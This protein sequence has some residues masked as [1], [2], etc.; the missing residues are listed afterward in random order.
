M[1]V[2]TQAP[3]AS[4]NGQD[5]LPANWCRAPEIPQW[6]DITK[7]DSNEAHEA[8][9]LANPHAGTNGDGEQTVSLVWRD[10]GAHGHKPDSNSIALA[11]EDDDSATGTRTV[12]NADAACDTATTI[13]GIDKLQVDTFSKCDDKS[14]D[15]NTRIGVPISTRRGGNVKTDGATSLFSQL[16]LGNSLTHRKDHQ[17]VRA[18][19]LL[20]AGKDGLMTSKDSKEYEHGD[21]ARPKRPNARILHDPSMRIRGLDEQDEKD[22]SSKEQPLRHTSG[23]GR[24]SPD[25]D[26]DDRSERD[27]DGRDD[28]SQGE[29]NENGNDDGDDSDA[30]ADAD[31]NADA[32]A[33]E[34]DIESD[35]DD[36][37]SDNG[38][39]SGDADD[40]AN[41]LMRS[42][43]KHTEI[44]LAHR[45]VIPADLMKQLR[46]SLQNILARVGDLPTCISC[47]TSAANMNH[48]TQHSVIT[49]SNCDGEDRC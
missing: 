44:L 4:F 13:A 2:N 20:Q 41:S 5:L 39:D 48:A 27:R 30:D 40:A 46:D 12:V 35:N 38:S 34:G 18:P 33:G 37:V 8:T 25:Q 23:F 21:V 32:D 14:L 9:P 17:D 15:A 16:D 31:A 43:R 47:N 29:I 19:P 7:V 49:H 11:M 24:S 26:E 36:N 10:S 3:G 28:D 1:N 45:R 6:R 42:L 22:S